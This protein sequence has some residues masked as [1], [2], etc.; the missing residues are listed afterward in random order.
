MAILSSL[1]LQI[2]WKY[3]L[4]M[5][6]PNVPNIN[7]GKTVL[8]STTNHNYQKKKNTTNHS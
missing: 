6:L 7:E 3:N 8:P 1:E 5:N 2:H 4:Q